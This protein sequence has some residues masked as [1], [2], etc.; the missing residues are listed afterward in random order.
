MLVSW[1][2]IFMVHIAAM[3][4]AAQIGTACPRSLVMPPPASPAATAAPR[5]QLLIARLPHP[6]RLFPSSHRQLSPP[7]QHARVRLCS[8]T[9]STLRR[10]LPSTPCPPRP[11]PPGAMI[12]PKVSPT[13]RL[14][15]T[16]AC[17][18]C[19]RRTDPDRWSS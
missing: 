11:L 7:H 13:L 17:R 18:P 16:L 15:W 10:A 12:L 9:P 4:G 14:H 3:F 1:A 8:C 19:V 5:P 2:K 6:R